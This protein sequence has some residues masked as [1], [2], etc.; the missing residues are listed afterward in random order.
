[1]VAARCFPFPT[2]RVRAPHECGALAQLRM[3][4]PEEPFHF[5][6]AGLDNV[7][8]AGIRCHV[9]PNCGEEGEIPAVKELMSALARVV[10][11]KE[12]LLT[13]TEIRFL[14]KVL[15]KKA[16]EFAEIIGVRPE[17]VSRWEN[18]ANK[19][20]KSACR[21]IRLAYIQLSGDKRLSRA[22]GLRED[23]QRWI[24]SLGD[25]AGKD[26]I[27]GVFHGK[28]WEVG[29]TRYSQLTHPITTA[30]DVHPTKPRGPRA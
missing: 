17:E 13:G 2:R 24:T 7:Y 11:Q 27:L 8:L 29:A 22:I 16:T 19:P 21:L 10:V 28:T 30:A 5:V 14:R 4:T 12:C 1:M 6:E 15:R 20:E 23:F 26:A 3:A 25:C 9:C 18:D